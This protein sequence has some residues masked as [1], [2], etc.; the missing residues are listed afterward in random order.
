MQS[1]T[2]EKTQEQYPEHQLDQQ[3]NRNK[4]AGAVIFTNNYAKNQMQIKPLLIF[5]PD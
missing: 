4:K 5:Y 2:T 3:F 1:P